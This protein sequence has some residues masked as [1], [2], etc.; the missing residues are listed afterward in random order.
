MNGKRPDF[1][2]RD[3]EM[4]LE[5]GALTAAGQELEG[6]KAFGVNPEALRA[7]VRAPSGEE[8]MGGGRGPGAFDGATEAIVRHHGRPSLL[9]R[10]DRIE[11]PKSATWRRRLVRYLPTLEDR[12]KSVG[13]VELLN[14]H[15]FDWVG[16]A[17]VVG[18]KVAVT[19]RHVAKE[20]AQRRGKGFVFLRQTSAPIKASVDFR[21][22]YG[23]G[24]AFEVGVAKVLYIADDGDS[25][26]DMAVMQL[27]S[28]RELPDPIELADDDPGANDY[29]GVVGYP[30]RDSRNDYD[31]MVRVFGDIY[32]KKRFAPGQVASAPKKGFVFT[33]DCS[34][35]G[36]NSGSV[37]LDL[38][39][40]RAVGLHFGGRYEQANYA[41]K[42]SALRNIITKNL[43]ARVFSVPD[44]TERSKKKKKKKA[45]TK[46]GD[47]I[48]PTSYFNES[49]SGY[50][51]E[52]LGNAKAHHVPLPGLGSWKN[53]VTPVN[54]KNGAGKHVL[55]YTH[56]SVVMSKSRRLALFTAVNI[57]GLRLRRIARGGDKWFKDGR[58][59][60]E[61]QIGNAEAYL[62]NRLDRGHMV[63]RLDP[64]WG[65]LAEQANEDTFHYT[66][67]C[68]QHE[69]LNQKVWN[70]LEDY[71]LDEAGARDL[72]VTVF[73]GPVLRD[74]DGYY[75][76]V[77][78]PREFWK[79]A[80]VVDD[81]SGALAASAYV[82]SQEDM[83]ADLTEFRY[84]AF[85][86]YQVS[87]A[88]I[89][90]IT[91]LSFGKLSQHD[92]FGADEAR[93]STRQRIRR[94]SDIRFR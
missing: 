16:T 17:W 4:R 31:A 88:E 42:A 11:R 30:A 46:K 26:P 73:T 1:L 18:D 52:F 37:V 55:D 35:L 13:R 81:D 48:R 3:E 86:T 56:F 87:I 93:V 65:D 7:R 68:P 39:S 60:D 20:F 90:S 21:E 77:Q 45:P 51:H 92:A 61:L 29:V 57:D 10:G 50:D 66:N 41:V 63:R 12:V 64:V 47:P 38:V 9:V 62:S 23:N 40:G 91:G 28:S 94:S 80:V 27:S 74:D 5:I 22:E 53:D 25:A 78:L 89:E 70:D 69:D 6:A 75:K 71:V 58:I 59:D 79:V 72:K 43:S 19:N 54:G 24:A 14:H 49:H 85:G 83:I 34:T 82:L 44:V 8:S 15:T 67:S 36:G 84:G 32:D 33:H 2:Q 76:T